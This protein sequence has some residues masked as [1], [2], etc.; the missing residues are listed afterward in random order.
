MDVELISLCF[1]HHTGLQEIPLYKFGNRAILKS[2]ADLITLK[3]ATEKFLNSF[4]NLSASD[5]WEK[6]VSV[7]QSP[8]Q[9]YPKTTPIPYRE[10][11]EYFFDERILCEKKMLTYEQTNQLNFGQLFDDDGVLAYRGQIERGLANGYGKLLY[12]TGVIEYEGAFKDNLQHGRGEL[13]SEAGDLIYRGDF[14]GGVRSGKGVEYYHTGGKM[15]QGHWKDDQWHGW[16][17]WYSILGDQLFKGR[18]DT[19]KPVKNE[20]SNLDRNGHW[21]IVARVELP[22]KNPEPAPVSEIPVS[23]PSKV[24]FQT[25]RKSDD[26]QKYSPNG[27]STMPCTELNPQKILA[28]G[29]SQSDP[30]RCPSPIKELTD[31]PQIIKYDDQLSPTHTL[32]PSDSQDKDFICIKTE[33]SKSTLGDRPR[34]AADD[35]NPV[36][37]VDV[38]GESELC[39]Q[40]T[41]DEE[42]AL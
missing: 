31:Q 30:L 8:D 14:L 1:P 26:S 40:E 39:R 41:K 36:E 34:V 5:F 2:K 6:Q 22:E 18:F 29:S 17:C 24:G 16:G 32:H 10:D 33:G 25:P 15:Y 11:S 23:E 27:E 7:L 42:G 12:P 37:I 20:K 35:S 3:N 13:C 28:N 9:R 19:N 21:P 38:L 4:R